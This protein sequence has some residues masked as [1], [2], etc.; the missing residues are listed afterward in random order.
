MALGV[1]SPEVQKHLL[2]I[3]K[4]NSFAMEERDSFEIRSSDAEDFIEV[5]IWGLQEMLEKA[6]E[7]GANQNA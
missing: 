3:A 5:S 1:T 4:E 2:E 6:Y 7:L